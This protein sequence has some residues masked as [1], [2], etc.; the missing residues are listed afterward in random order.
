MPLD[1]VFWKRPFLAQI[2]PQVF[3]YTTEAT[4]TVH[5]K[6]PGRIGSYHLFRLPPALEDQPEHDLERRD[7]VEAFQQV[8]TGDDAMATLQRLA[9]VVVNAPTGPV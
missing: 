9:D 6:A 3:D 4:C 8:S 5:D 1:F 2:E 7:W